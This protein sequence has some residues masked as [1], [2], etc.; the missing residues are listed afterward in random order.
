M[1][2]VMKEVFNQIILKVKAVIYH[3]INNYILVL[4][5]II[6]GMDMENK[7]IPMEVV[8]LGIG[9]LINDMVLVN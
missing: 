1:V 7:H 6:I 8:I 5:I 4:G 3:T 2:I 9:L